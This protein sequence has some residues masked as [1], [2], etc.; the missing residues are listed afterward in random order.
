MAYMLAGKTFLDYTNLFSPNDYKKM[1][2]LYISFLKINM[3]EKASFEF[4]LRKIDETGNYLLD[5]IKHNNLMSEKYDKTCK[6]LNYVEHLLM[7][8]SKVT[9]CFSISTFASL[10]CFP[11]GITSSSIGIKICVITAGIEKYRSII[12]KKKKKDDKIVLLGKDKLNSIKVLISKALIDSY[13]TD[14]EF[15]SVNNVLREYYE[16]KEEIKNPETSVEYTI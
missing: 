10:V 11:V 5:E 4:R 1:I 3:V 6:N 8:A 12:N 2:K 9:G 13:I 14:D 7:Q 16:M 15:F